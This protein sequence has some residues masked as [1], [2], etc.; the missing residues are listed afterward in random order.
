[1]GEACSEQ[2]L[3][4]HSAKHQDQLVVLKLEELL[5]VLPH[6]AQGWRVIEKISK[7]AVVLVLGPLSFI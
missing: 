5:D 2:G 3:C 4:A 1:M 7:L 6:L